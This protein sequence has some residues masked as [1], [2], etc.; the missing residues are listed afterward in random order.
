MAQQAT[1]IL[2]TSALALS[3]AIHTRQV[4]CAEVMAATLAA[5]DRFNPVVNAIVSL[6]DPDALLKE[7]RAADAEL[8]GGRSRGWMHGIPQA[9]KD[10][11]A[12]KGLPNTQGSPLFAGIPAEA[13]AIFVE[14]IRAAG[15]IIVGKTNT[16]EFGFGSQTYNPVFGPTRNAYD[17]A[18]TSG[19][20]WPRS[21][22]PGK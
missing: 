5:I 12:A 19:G 15:A 13:D 16:P 11:A 20:R 3:D 9:I 18:K 21:P 8:A 17:Q 4:S 1:D 10:L 6:R 7:A 22:W 14:R 2:A